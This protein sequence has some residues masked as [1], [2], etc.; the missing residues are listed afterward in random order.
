[1]YVFIDKIKNM[2]KNVEKCWIW[3]G[4][5]VVPYNCCQNRAITKLKEIML[6][7]SQEG[8]EEHCFSALFFWQICLFLKGDR[9]DRLTWSRC[10]VTSREFLSKCKC[11]GMIDLH[12]QWNHWK[13][14]NRTYA[15]NTLLI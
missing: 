7:S 8:L 15:F 6:D 3:K 9:E 11:G 1:M 14:E 13:Q 12:A 2:L 10:V 4:Q 5:V